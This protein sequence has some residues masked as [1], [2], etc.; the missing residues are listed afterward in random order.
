M[1]RFPSNEVTP[2]PAT[3]HAELIALQRVQ[4]LKGL[5]KTIWQNNLT[6]AD[7]DTDDSGQ[8]HG[9]C[10]EFRLRNRFVEEQS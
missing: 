1:R 8:D 5:Y 9:Q 6:A 10:A 3:S 4:P 7:A 2:R